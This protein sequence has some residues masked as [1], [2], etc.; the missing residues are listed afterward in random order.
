MPHFLQ[1]PRLFGPYPEAACR[2]LENLLW[3][4]EGPKQKLSSTAWGEIRSLASIRTLRDLWALR[5][6]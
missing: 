2:L 1:N 5:K 6:V 3:V 4:G